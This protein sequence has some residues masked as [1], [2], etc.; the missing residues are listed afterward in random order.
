MRQR[1]SIRL[2]EYDY[3]Q[4]GAYFVTVVTQGRECLFGDIVDGEL[5]L[6][7][8]G[9]MVDDAL[10]GLPLYYDIVAIDTHIVMP[11]H[12]H[13]IIVINA[14][15]GAGLVPALGFVRAGQPQR[16]AP[17]G[18]S[19]AAIVGRFK[20]MTTK[21]YIRGVVG[22]AWP[23]FEGRVWQRNYYEHVIRNEVE[24]QTTRC[25]IMNNPTRWPDDGERP[26]YNAA[27]AHR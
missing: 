15:V 5:R 4:P 6:S 17:T 25:Y 12:I 16:V 11:N 21:A 2:K 24:L 1:R 3:A 14:H 7:D 13:A 9:R 27:P 18:R 20:S 10:V 23:S 22:E 8:A 19:L 26:D